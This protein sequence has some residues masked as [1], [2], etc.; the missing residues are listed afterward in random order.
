M[1]LHLADLIFTVTGL[2]LD[3]SEGSSVY[4]QLGPWDPG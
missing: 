3:E 4:G 1:V 2:V